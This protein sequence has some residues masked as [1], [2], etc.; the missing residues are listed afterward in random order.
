[1]TPTSICGSRSPSF[2]AGGSG[3]GKAG[4]ICK[5][6]DCV[7]VDSFVGDVVGFIGGGGDEAMVDVEADSGAVVDGAVDE[8]EDGGEG[9]AISTAI[10]IRDGLC[11]FSSTS[12]INMCASPVPLP[13]T[14]ILAFDK[15]TS[16]NGDV[17][18]GVGFNTRMARENIVRCLGVRVEEAP[19]G[20]C[21]SSTGGSGIEDGGVG[22]AAIG[23][24]VVGSSGVDGARYAAEIGLII[25]QS[26]VCS[27][28]HS[29]PMLFPPPCE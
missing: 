20:D 8:E 18:A 5:G 11:L 24:D 1:M 7:V 29:G 9:I 19:E 25:S 2:C 4:L 15:L 21:G 22:S 26:F 13:P 28:I 14:L 6:C 27:I 16:G 12:V 3:S 10:R 23:V 17:A